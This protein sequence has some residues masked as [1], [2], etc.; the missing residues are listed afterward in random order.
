MVRQENGDFVIA[1]VSY[2][3]AWSYFE[4]MKFDGNGFP[5]NS[6][7]YSG[8]VQT[9]FNHYDRCL[10]FVLQ[11]DGKLVASGYTE[12][13]GSGVVEFATA[14]YLNDSINVLHLYGTVTDSVTHNPIPNHPVII[15]NDTMNGT[16][17]P[18]HK[19]VYTDA[20]GV[21]NDTVLLPSNLLNWRYIV[22]TYDGNSNQYYFAS[23][24]G[25]GDNLH[26]FSIYS[27][28]YSSCK[29]GF[30]ASQDTSNP[31]TFHFIDQS[32]GNITSWYWTFGDNSHSFDR[33]PV[34][35]FLHAG[36]V[37]H[38]CLIVKDTINSCCDVSCMDVIPG[39][40]VCQANFHFS[41][42]TI[43]PN[44]IVHFFDASTGNPTSWDW[45]FGD[46]L[47][48]ID[49]FSSLQN[50]VHLFS[51]PGIYTVC[52]TISGFNCSSSYCR[53]IVITDSVTYHQ[54][55]GQ[56]FAGSF[57]LQ[58]G[59]ASLFSIDTSQSYL[60]YTEASM[61]DSNGVYFFTLVPDGNYMIFA[62]PASSETYLPT[63][64]GDVIE[65]EE[66]T[67]ITLG[68]PVNPYNIHLIQA[69]TM[70]SGAGSASGHI[71]SGKL[72]GSMIEKIT[73]TL[74]DANHHAI[75]F[76]RVNSGG[77]FHFPTLDYGTY[78]LHPEMAGVT[79]DMVKIE[80]TPS[81]PHAEVV[82]TFTGDHING[83]A[84]LK[85]GEEFSIYPNPVT[86][87]LM[88][89]IRLQVPGEIRIELCTIT[90]QIISEIRKPAGSVRT[91]ISVPFSEYKNGIYV[92]RMHTAEGITITRKVVKAM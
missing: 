39:T 17:Y 27:C 23:G 6:F 26:D 44:S 51:G 35:T 57:P 73:V 89:S 4:L 16:T 42:D 46:P 79:S 67:L 68:T 82:M 9:E 61:I 91:L 22:R 62:I 52:L 78:Y 66:A 49:N 19:I 31:L 77:E 38:V 75:S 43:V 80:I 60:P 50:S 90:G 1:G 69:A 81:K 30:V 85:E 64:Y 86:D 40:S 76:S 65:W 58:E 33:N 32:E 29:A 71:N 18:H 11:S 47:S 2:L 55:Y 56:V 20:A 5:V 28:E 8:R 84:D 12:L 37:Y 48:G 92:L 14:R 36:E 83:T 34:H 59:L 25:S 54:L 10:G 70:T 63:Y 24:Y 88:L 45:N 41:P 87:N 7:G 72:P 21:Y 15:D 13:G 74:L 53:N 3:G